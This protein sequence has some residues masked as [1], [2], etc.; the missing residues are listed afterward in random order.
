M[1]FHGLQLLGLAIVG[2]GISVTVSGLTGGLLI[3]FFGVILSLVGVGV[4]WIIEDRIQRM[5]S[6][7][8]T[9]P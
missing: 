3:A 8:G 9:R 5:H 1:G 6:G 7:A 4:D 2:F